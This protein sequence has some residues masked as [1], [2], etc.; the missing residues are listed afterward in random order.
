MSANV[1]NRFEQTRGDSKDNPLI[2]DGDFETDGGHDLKGKTSTLLLDVTAEETI[3]FAPGFTGTVTELGMVID[4]TIGA[5]NLVVTPS[6]DGVPITGGA[7]SLAAGSI[8]GTITIQIPGALN[9]FTDV[10]S[11][12]FHNTAAGNNVNATVTLEYKPTT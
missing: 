10:S 11:I 1:L 8:G 4:A 7:L 2:L 12:S 3:Y 5:A 9:N 6:I